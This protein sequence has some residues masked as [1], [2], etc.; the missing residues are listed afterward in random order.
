MRSYYAAVYGADDSDSNLSSVMFPYSD[1]DGDDDDSVVEVHSQPINNTANRRRGFGAH[2]SEKAANTIRR[3]LVKFHPCINTMWPALE[4]TAP[5]DA[6][7]AE[8]PQMISRLLKP[9]QLAG[10][11]WMQS[12]EQSKWKGGL[13]GDEMGLGKTIQ[14]VSLIVV[15]KQTTHM[16]TYFDPT[17]LTSYAVRLSCKAAYTGSCPTCC[18]GTVERRDRKLHQWEAKDLGLACNYYQDQGHD[19]KGHQKV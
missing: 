13:L 5:I 11:A 14:A 18:P 3:K 6:G 15:R 19:H 4:E 7:K 2:K 1:D 10:L 16:L 8:Q 17:I 9:F 12:M